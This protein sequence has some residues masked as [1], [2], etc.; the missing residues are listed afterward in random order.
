MLLRLGNNLSPA[1]DFAILAIRREAFAFTEIRLGFDRRHGPDLL[2]LLIVT[3]VELLQ[4]LL[5]LLL[6]ALRTD[7]ELPRQ[8]DLLVAS[9]FGAARAVW[10]VE[11]RLLELVVHSVNYGSEQ[12]PH[13]L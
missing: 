7:L 5:L 11:F 12:S 6:T 4:P 13:R 10:S 8:V 9:D 3:L 2:G 1:A